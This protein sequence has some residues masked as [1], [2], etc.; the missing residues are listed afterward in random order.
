MLYA[1]LQPRVAGIDVVRHHSR[2]G[3]SMYIKAPRSRTR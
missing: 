2:R 1:G 3:S